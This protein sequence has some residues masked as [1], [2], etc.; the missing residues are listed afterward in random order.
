MLS[1]LNGGI[2]VCFCHC[3]FFPMS[4]SLV[5][6]EQRKYLNKGGARCVQWAVASTFIILCQESRS[7]SHYLM[8]NVQLRLD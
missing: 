8:S 5:Y 3:S 2:E 7:C 4:K 6:V 1:F